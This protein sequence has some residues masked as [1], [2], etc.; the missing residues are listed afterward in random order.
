MKPRKLS[1]KIILFLGIA[2]LA[3][4]ILFLTFLYF[5]TKSAV[6]Q[7]IRSQGIQTA[8]LIAEDIDKDIYKEFVTNKNESPDYWTIRN[9]LNDYR[10]KTGSMYVYTLEASDS[11][12]EILIDGLP[13]SDEMAAPIGTATTGT[14]LADVE[15]A[16]KGKTDS[17]SLIDDPDYGQYL[18]AF[19]PITS[20][21]GEILG[22]LGVDI[23][24]TN[25]GAIQNGVIKSILP[26]IFSI[27][28]VIMTGILVVVYMYIKKRLAPISTLTNSVQLLADGKINAAAEEVRQ[29]RSSGNDEIHLLTHHY[30]LAMD[31]LDGILRH[32]QES[33]LSVLSEARRLD[34]IIETVK[35]ANNEITSNIYSIAKGSEHQ[36][37]SNDEAVQAMEEMTIGIQRI[38]DS[39]TT[40][41]ESSNEMMELVQQS[42]DQSKSVISQIEEVES[43]VISTE[44]LINKLAS[45]YSAIEETIRVISDITDQTNLLAL[46]ASIEAARAGEFGKGF[47][48]VANEVK[49]LAEQ[50]RTSAETV[51]AHILS[52]K[53][54]TV[55]ALKEME[56]SVIIVKAG[57][58]SVEGI[59]HSLSKVL[60]SVNHVNNEIQDVSAV[61]EELSASS[62]E[63]LAST[64]VIKSLVDQAVISTKEVAV[65]TDQQVESVQTLE[66]TM[67]NLRNTSL[68]LEKSIQQFN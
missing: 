65:S 13:E 19:A 48:V 26:Y 44:K 56:K 42:N 46:N 41:A 64:E 9:N 12:L 61:T 16:L 32:T 30:L 2:I 43:S 66:Q 7:T 18:S 49:K 40:V 55:E 22:I 60:T 20:E 39:S 45:G 68:E 21:D 15:N 11:K 38:A 14:T 31:Q 58:E 52:F 33:T 3:L 57:T 36:K 5:T 34:E 50:S 4:L 24:A 10:N 51:S 27:L 37:Q 29:I 25:V 17:T 6:E 62:E 67:E 23:A 63:L 47:A 54:V 28:F 53:N 1:S 59:G 35:S 8:Q